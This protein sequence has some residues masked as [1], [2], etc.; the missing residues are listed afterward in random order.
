MPELLQRHSGIAEK[1]ITQ[2]LPLIKTS[3]TF[4]DSNSVGHVE[5]YFDA[6]VNDTKTLE[7]IFTISL[8]HTH[9]WVPSDVT[10]PFEEYILGKQIKMYSKMCTLTQHSSGRM[11]QLQRTRKNWFSEWWGR[12]PPPKMMQKRIIYQQ[13]ESH[14]LLIL[15]K[16]KMSLKLSQ[17]GMALPSSRPVCSLPPHPSPILNLALVKLS[18]LPES[19]HEIPSCVHAL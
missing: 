7:P 18:L 1:G 6:N 12:R 19:R 4:K 10:L 14:C 11:F 9:F 3:E 13:E 2:K 17:C 15:Q 5:W 16:K 8:K